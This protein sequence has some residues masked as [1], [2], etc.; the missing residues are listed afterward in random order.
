LEQQK[1]NFGKFTETLFSCMRGML[2]ENPFQ[3]LPQ[4][5]MPVFLIYGNADRLIPNKMLHPAMTIHDVVNDAKK[6]IPG[7][8]TEIAENCGHYL[9][10][11]N[12]HLLAQRIQQFYLQ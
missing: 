10:F 9:P 2:S 1:E 5:K 6:N 3:F 8:K 7:V 12:P 4:L 11:E